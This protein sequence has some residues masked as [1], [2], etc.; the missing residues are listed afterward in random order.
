M[1]D[2]KTLFRDYASDIRAW[3][4]EKSQRQAD[5]MTNRM[6]AIR[7]K[8]NYTQHDLIDAVVGV[9]QFRSDTTPLTVFM[10]NCGSSGSHWIEPMLQELGGYQACGEIYLSHRIRE[11]ISLL[12]PA[13]RTSFL[14]AVHIA[15]G[16][17]DPRQLV[18][19]RF[20]NTAHNWETPQLFHAPARTVFIARNPIDIVVSRSFRK[21]SYRRFIAPEMGDREYVRRNTNLVNRFYTQ[22]L[23]TGLDGFVR[24]EDVRA[25]GVRA[26]DFLMRV[27]N[28]PRQVSDLAGVLR[29]FAKDGALVARTNIYSGPT[30]DIPDWVRSQVASEL[31]DSPRS[32]GYEY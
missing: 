2:W 16:R 8:L 7:R 28:D 5:K 10:P 13:Q 17:R 14:D 32:F 1:R 4:P 9:A 22:A 15:H 11:S 6:S 25:D 26:L 3:W 20:V 30:V 19:T 27:L 18:H 12:S 24:Y 21:S 29:D 31:N 23:Q